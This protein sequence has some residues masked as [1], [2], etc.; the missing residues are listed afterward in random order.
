MV[1]ATYKLFH[2]KSTATCFL[3]REPKSETAD[4]SSPN[5]DT[6]WLVTAAHVLEKTEGESAVLVLREKVGLYEYK[7]HD[8]PITIRRDDKPLWTKHPKF[9]TAVLKLETLPEFPV[10]TLPMDVLADDETLQ[11]A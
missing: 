7:R 9:D 5:S 2:P 4:D 1:E 8:Y 10:A 6:V 11:A 3:L